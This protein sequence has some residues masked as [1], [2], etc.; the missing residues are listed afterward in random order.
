MFYLQQ[1]QDKFLTKTCTTLYHTL[2]IPASTLV[3]AD[4]IMSKPIH[5]AQQWLTAPIQCIKFSR[6]MDG[7]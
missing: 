5:Q 6:I 1:L 7:T 3:S 2:T 4:L